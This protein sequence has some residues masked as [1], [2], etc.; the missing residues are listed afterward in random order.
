MKTSVGWLPASTAIAHWRNHRNKFITTLLLII[1]SSLSLAQQIK[2]E[3]GKNGS[4]S[5]AINPV[6]WTTEHLYDANAHFVEGQSIPYRT[7]IYSLSP[8]THTVILEWDNRKDNKSAI[9]FVTS[10]QRISETVNPLKGLSGAFDA[11]TFFTIPAPTK[12]RLVTGANGAQQ[13]PLYRFNQLPESEKKIALYNGTPISISYIQEGDPTKSYATTK[14][15]LEFK[16]IGKYSRNVV[17]AWGG[18][19]ARRA[20]WGASNISSDK[21][22]ALYRS[23][24]VT[25]NTK[26]CNLDL[27]T[28]TGAV[29]FIP[30]CELD[31]NATFCD[32]LTYT[33]SVTTDALQPNYDWKITGGSIISG[34]ATATIQVKWNDVSNATLSV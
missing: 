9:D 15:K 14:L 20:D 32:N 22:N 31:A 4:W 28:K 6:S 12:N 30:T 17:I 29:T 18:H 21:Y 2:F 34:Q 16:V 1:S 10:Y 27:Y 13:Q 33:Y 23:R 7:T 5:S 24:V 25:L 3:Q 8:G 26:S 19:V 11:P